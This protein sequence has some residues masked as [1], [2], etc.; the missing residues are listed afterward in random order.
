MRFEVVKLVLSWG[1][2]S[3]LGLAKYLPSL[4]TQVEHES[5]IPT[6]IVKSH[7]FFYEGVQKNKQTNILLHLT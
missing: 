4:Q 2:I 3:G 6:G 7:S 5:K 1:H